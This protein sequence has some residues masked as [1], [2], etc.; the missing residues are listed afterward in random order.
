MSRITAEAILDIGKQA[1]DDTLSEQE[2][3]EWVRE[4]CY[5]DAG[6]ERCAYPFDLV[7]GSGVIAAKV[8]NIENKMLV[9]CW[10][11]IP[12]ENFDAPFPNTGVCIDGKPLQE[13]LQDNYVQV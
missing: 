12:I 9:G 4:H 3:A 1:G 10:Y 6:N 7:F 13:Q 8:M 2:R 5:T 11:S